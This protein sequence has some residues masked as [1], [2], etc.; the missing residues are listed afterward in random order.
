MTSK[1][2]QI[3][4]AMNALEQA[5]TNLFNAYFNA[6]M[7]EEAVEQSQALNAVHSKRAKFRYKSEKAQH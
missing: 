1:Q 7:I 4:D 6:G 5:H 2:K 3:I